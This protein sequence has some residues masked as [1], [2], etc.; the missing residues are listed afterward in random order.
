MANIIT[1]SPRLD[2]DDEPPALNC[3]FVFMF[4][5][6][7][8]RN[9]ID[10]VEVT[11]R[12]ATYE[13]IYTVRP[14]LISAQVMYQVDVGHLTLRTSLCET[15]RSSVDGKAGLAGLC[16]LSIT[17]LGMLHGET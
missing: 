16:Q 9:S 7:N 12:H 1:K 2:V 10:H 17:H 5:Y 3:L 11:V 4:F 15:L 13:A 6:L 8:C 14:P